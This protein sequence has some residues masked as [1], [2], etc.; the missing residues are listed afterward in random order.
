MSDRHHRDA[1]TRPEEENMPMK[2]GDQAVILHV[3]PTDWLRKWGPYP[4]RQSL[5]G[6]TLTVL[7]SLENEPLTL[8]C[9][10]GL[11]GEQDVLWPTEYVS[12]IG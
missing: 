7:G 10:A 3:P 11:H 4:E 12:K 8:L 9:F 5:V 6:K 2:W 1:A